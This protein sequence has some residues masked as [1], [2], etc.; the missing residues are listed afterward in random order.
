M[1]DIIPS[2]HSPRRLTFFT[3]WLVSFLL[4]EKYGKFS[5]QDRN[6]PPKKE[7]KRMVGRVHKYE[8]KITYNHEDVYLPT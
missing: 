1:H 7:G 5:K 4:E 3:Y 6:R 8:I 2:V